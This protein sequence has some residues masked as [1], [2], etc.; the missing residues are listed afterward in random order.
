MI[1]L[2]SSVYLNR[3]YTDW[4]DEQSA[5]NIAIGD[6]PIALVKVDNAKELGAQLDDVWASAQHDNA[7]NSANCRAHGRT[8]GC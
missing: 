5:A 1:T 4:L 6:G 7:V 8:G 3:R 2:K